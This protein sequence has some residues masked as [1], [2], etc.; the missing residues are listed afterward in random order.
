MR[1][2][3]KTTDMP[4]PANPPASALLNGTEAD[5]AAGL[6][7]I[8]QSETPDQTRRIAFWVAVLLAVYGAL[9]YRYVLGMSFVL[10]DYT[11]LDKVIH[12]KFASLWT[13]EN[14]LWGWYRPWSRELHFWTLSRLFGPNALPFRVASVALWAG[15]LVAYYTFVRRLQGTRAA[16]VATVGA[17]TL[18]AWGSTLGWAAGVQEL[19]M[20]L[21]ALVFLHAMARRR[22]FTALLALAGALLSK[23]T[24]AVL[25]AIALLFV[26]AMDRD[27][28]GVALRRVAPQFVVVAFWV[29]LHPFLTAR[30]AG[31]FE[32]PHS[33]GAGI[34]L[35][36]ITLRTLLS[37]VNLEQWPSP[38]TGWLDAIIPALPSIAL[39]AL[40]TAWALRRVKSPVAVAGRPTIFAVGWAVLGA[41]PLFMPGVGWLSYYALFCALGVWA[42]M[43]GL[44]ARR[45]WLAAGFIGL[46]AALQAAH[47]HTPSNEWG[48]DW[49]LRRTAYF[50][51]GLKQQLMQRHPALPPHSRLY[52]ASV[53]V[54][55]GIGQ[56]WFNP[57]LRVWY[58]DSTMVA[59]FVRNYVPRR[60][61][62]RGFDYFFRF[63]DSTHVW[64]ETVPGTENLAEARRLNPQWETDHGALA[65]LLGRAGDWRGAAK[66]TKKLITVSPANP[67]YAFNLAVCL[68]NLGDTLGMKR[69]EQL[70]DSLRS[71][72]TSSE[73]P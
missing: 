57:A 38:D 32:R 65:I 40:G 49:F 25:P 45:P 16:V 39:L 8:G 1:D 9:Q 17:A 71:A 6:D 28:P 36:G 59:G 63:D 12:A 21:F 34:S 47:A 7:S 22:G 51:A 58:D 33:A 64:F 43:C 30:L 60:A 19:W 73:S 68:G 2:G 31:S 61:G 5:D 23:E 4:A 44:L 48:D 55:T 29:V 50:E 62:E 70:A 13:S 3:P 15:V 24:A 27:P 26:L 11:I 67:Q 56:P 20:L 18:A 52:F 54:G 10:D 14:P 72:L 42:T 41:L 37:V 66:E 35:L 69:Y 53:P 46:M